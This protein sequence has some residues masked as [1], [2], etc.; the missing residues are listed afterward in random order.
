MWPKYVLKEVIHN[1]PY[2]SVDY[3]L[4]FRIL[5]I[6]LFL[7]S[8]IMISVHVYSVYVLL[9]LRAFTYFPMCMYIFDHI[10]HMHACLC[11]GSASCFITHRAVSEVG[12]MYGSI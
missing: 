9:L 7:Y 11:S 12:K 4:I 8:I 3:Y 10:G 1:C 5:L 2:V 6:Q